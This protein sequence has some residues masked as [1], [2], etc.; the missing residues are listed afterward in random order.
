MQKLNLN[1]QVSIPEHLILI[2]K[3]EYKELKNEQMLGTWWSMKD[4]EFKLDKK[5]NWILDNILYS[6]KFKDRL[7]VGRGGCV[8]YP[9]SQGEK[10]V[11]KAN[12]MSK[13]LDRHFADIF[14]Q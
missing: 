3:Q 14:N 2:E 4:L 6:P 12:E 11:F 10:W 7:D 5:R 9:K 8:Y 1:L 13:F